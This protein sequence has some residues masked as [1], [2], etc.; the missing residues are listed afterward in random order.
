ME[1]PKYLLKSDKIQ[2]NIRRF[3]PNQKDSQVVFGHETQATNVPLAIYFY[4]GKKTPNI[5]DYSTVGCYF[6]IIDPYDFI[7]SFQI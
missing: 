3:R 5:S 7:I 1:S 6:L 4:S 2:R